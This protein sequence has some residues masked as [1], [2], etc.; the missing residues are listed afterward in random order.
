M[1]AILTIG[2]CAVSGIALWVCFFDLKQHLSSV[3][4]QHVTSHGNNR[5]VDGME[6]QVRTLYSNEYNSLA[7]GRESKYCKDSTGSFIVRNNRA[8]RM[9]CDD[10]RRPD[11]LFA[12]TWSEVRKNVS[13]LQDINVEYSCSFMECIHLTSFFC[14]NNSA[15]ILVTRAPMIPQ[16]IMMMIMDLNISTILTMT[17]VIQITIITIQHMEIQTAVT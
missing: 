3:S 11:Y 2:L 15:H 10:L 7:Y 8:K 1:K 9:T 13:A 12:C 6:D 16:I 14:D 17:I 4:D 5:N